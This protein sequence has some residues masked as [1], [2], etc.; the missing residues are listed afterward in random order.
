MYYYKLYGMNVG[1]DLEFP[2][3]AA[4]E[5]QS[6]DNLQL[7]IENTKMPSEIEDSERGSYAFGKDRSW[8]HNR[9]AWILVEKGKRIRYKLKEGGNPSYLLSYILGYGM[10]MLSLQQGKLAI[11]CSALRNEQGVVLIAGESGSGKSTLSAELMDRG[12]DLMADDMLV[13]QPQKG[14]APV[15]YPAFPYQKLCRNA[16]MDRGYDLR[17]LLYINEEKDKFLVPYEGEFSLE[18]APV[19]AML[20]L[21]LTREGEPQ[22]VELSGMEKFAATANNLFLR[23]LLGKEKFAP[24]NG[25]KYLDFSANTPIFMLVRPEG[26]ETLCQISRM[27]FECLEKL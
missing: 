18:P 16:A 27:A 4:I 8:L 11:H 9:T 22:C 10:A 7:T 15:A 5:P 19:R 1:S 12:Y 2:Q 21:A 23:K 6:P 13:V 3:L 14:K 25:Q 17:K 24:E 20:I 26:K